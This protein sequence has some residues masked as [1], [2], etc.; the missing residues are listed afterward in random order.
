MSLFS[1]MN[2]ERRNRIRKEIYDKQEGKCHYC[3]KELSLQSK[4]I[5]KRMVIDHVVPRAKGGTN[6][7]DNLVGTCHHCNNRKG[8]QDYIYFVLRNRHAPNFTP[9]VLK[10]YLCLN[11]NHSNMLSLRASA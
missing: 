9:L 7:Q 3:S 11:L 5:N 4:K 10:E 2:S 6:C 8:D 1:A